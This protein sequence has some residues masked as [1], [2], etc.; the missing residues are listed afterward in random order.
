MRVEGF[1]IQVLDKL[2][3]DDADH[4]RILVGAIDD[5]GDTARTTQAAARTLPCIAT[6][7]R[8]HFKKF[9]H[10]WMTPMAGLMGQ[11]RQP[12]PVAGCFLMT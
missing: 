10:D 8:N 5:A 9:A 1:V 11:D 6:G 7:L 2:V 4:L 3:V 12:R